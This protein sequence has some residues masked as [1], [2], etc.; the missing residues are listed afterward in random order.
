M[1]EKVRKWNET[2]TMREAYTFAD[3]TSKATTRVGS[4][5]S[6]VGAT[7][8]S[9]L[10]SYDSFGNIKTISIPISEDEQETII[11]Y[12]YDDQQQLVREDNKLLDE[13]YTYTYDRGGN[14]TSK[15]TYTYTTGSL[16]SLT[17]TTTNY[18][19]SGDRLTAIGSNVITY[20]DLGNP[21]TYGTAA[22]TWQNGRQLASINYNGGDPEYLY[23]YNDSGIRTSKTVNG[24]KHV[25]T[26]NGSQIVT[27]TWT[28]N[29]VEYVI[30]YLYDESGAPIGM[31]Y[32]TSEY[33]WR[34]FDNYYFEKN[35]FGDVVAIYN[36]TG[37]KI[38]SYKYDAW[39][40]CTAVPGVGTTYV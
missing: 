17:G 21:L 31:Q 15:T 24:V 2:L 20:D 12:Y 16:S 30:V 18:T 33:A 29:N 40:A 22:Y 37:T 4:F 7:S 19:Y 35:L 13:T 34:E 27:E 6:T 26:L 36:E 39:G 5:T 3:K 8:S 14:R 25:Y 9:Y 1:T 10:Y 11:R 28:Q 32:R 23:E 38:G